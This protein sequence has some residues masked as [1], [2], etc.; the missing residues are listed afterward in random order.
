MSGS[1]PPPAAER[2]SAVQ[3]RIRGRVQGVFFRAWLVERAAELALGGW[4]RNRR[5]GSVEA[6]FVGSPAA[7]AAA[8]ASCREGPPHARVRAVETA[9]AAGGAG[10]GFSQRP[11]A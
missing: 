11:T 1:T 6:L 5:N 4:V 3:V 9:P 2:P 10:P 8:V 7:V